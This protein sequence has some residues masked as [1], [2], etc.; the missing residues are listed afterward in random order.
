MENHRKILY[1]VGSWESWIFLSNFV[2]TKHLFSS[3]GD[4]L[5]LLSN[6]NYQTFY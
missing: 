6:T 2:M 5:H 4:V 3:T 1:A